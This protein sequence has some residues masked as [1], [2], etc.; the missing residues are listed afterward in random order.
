MFN[1]IVC[2][3]LLGITDIEVVMAATTRYVIESDG[4]VD[5]TITRTG[6]LVVSLDVVCYIDP[7][8]GKPQQEGLHAIHISFTDCYRRLGKAQFLHW[9]GVGERCHLASFRL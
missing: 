3:Y 8:T 1:I 5:V 9:K 7:V 4:I 2:L 6:Q